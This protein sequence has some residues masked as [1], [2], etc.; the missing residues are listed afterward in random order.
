VANPSAAAETH[1]PGGLMIAQGGYALEL[2]EA[3]VAPGDVRVEF[4]VSGPDGRPLTSYDVQ[5]ERRLHLIAVRRDLTGFQHVHPVLS[6]DGVW[7]ATLDVTAGDWRL[8]ADFKPSGADPL[9]LGADLAVAGDYRPATPVAPSR[10]AQVDDYSVTLEG[11][12][13]A[14]ADSRL[15][16]SVE[17]NGEPV[18]DLEPYLGAYGHLVVLRAGDLAYLHV[19]P[20]G[21]PGDGS[22]EPG[23]D[24]E[25]TASVPSNGTYHVFLDFR[26]R[27]VVRTAAFTLPT[28]GHDA[29]GPAHP[30]DAHTDH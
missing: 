29:P 21:A 6:A 1:V 17:R 11:A 27:G 24:V 18:T 8:F 19:H 22:T 12:L 14:G 16:L 30:G 13:T 3:E 28:R 10:T 25:F 15:T 7:S 20:E 4:T 5:H 2:A 23:P 9:T 26:H